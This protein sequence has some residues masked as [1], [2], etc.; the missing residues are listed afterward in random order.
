MLQADGTPDPAKA[1][2]WADPNG[3]EDLALWSESGG[4]SSNPK[5][6]MTGGGNIHLVGVVM[7]PN[8]QPM[9]LTGQFA[10]YLVNAQLVVSSI[11]L[12]SNNTMITMQVDANAAVTLDGLRPVGLVR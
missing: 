2:E 1:G 3:P 6:Q 5:Y 10:Q 9:N 12:S 11:D 4:G 8:A 7:A